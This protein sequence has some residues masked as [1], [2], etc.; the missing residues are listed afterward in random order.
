M[1]DLNLEQV[2]QYLEANKETE[3]V[4]NY[5]GQFS[6]VDATKVETFLGSD[7]GRS[8]KDKMNNIFLASYTKDGGGQEKIFDSKLKTAR[9]GWEKEAGIT[10]TP[11]QEKI[12]ELEERLNKSDMSK[13]KSDLTSKAINLLEYKDLGS[14]AHMFVGKDEEETSNNISTLNDFFKN[15]VDSEVEKRMKGESGR[16]HIGGN[17]PPAGGLVAKVEAARNKAIETRSKVDRAEYTKLKRELDATE[18][19]K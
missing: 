4:V 10:L 14:M 12:K 5:L 18:G 11:E 17:K 19:G 7:D 15:F 13:I 9:E 3:E 2:Q 1:E 6:A 16:E 8:T